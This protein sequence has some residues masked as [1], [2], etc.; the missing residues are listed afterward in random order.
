MADIEKERGDLLEVMESNIPENIR[1][2]MELAM[3]SFESQEPPVITVSTQGACGA[4]QTHY[5]V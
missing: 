5:S 3:L 2:L 1:P 4:E